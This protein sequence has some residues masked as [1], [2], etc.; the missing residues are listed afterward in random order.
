MP[1]V[2]FPF[3]AARFCLEQAGISP[4][5]VDI[6]AMPYAKIGLFNPARWHYAMRHW[7]APDRA[8]TA[9]FNGNRRYRR[10]VRMAN[11][12][13]REIGLDPRHVR[14][15]PVEH[16]MT[17][18]SSAYHLSGF[19]EKTAV[20]TIDGKGEYA[21]TMFGYAETRQYAKIK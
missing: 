17:H 5:E 15:V 21:T 13:M 4:D 9:I 10:N 14:L 3:E 7:Y 12:M 16:H 20:I 19:K 2:A 8:L 11:D 18:A 6:V 1:R